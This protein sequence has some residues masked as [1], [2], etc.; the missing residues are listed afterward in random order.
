[1]NLIPIVFL[2][3]LIHVQSSSIIDLVFTVKNL[4]TNERLKSNFLTMISSLFEHTSIDNLRLHVIGDI[5]SQQFV[6]KT[7]ENL[8]YHSQVFAFFLTMQKKTFVSF[9]SDRST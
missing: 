9:L 8:H 5:D 1:M 2:V 4:V 6:I 3:C 7:L